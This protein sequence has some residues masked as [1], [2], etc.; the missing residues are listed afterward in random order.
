MFRYKL[1]TL[2][3]LLAVGPPLLAGAWWIGQKEIERRR[4]RSFAELI[5]LIQ[6]TVRP[7][8]WEGVSGPG[9]IT[10]FATSCCV[11]LPPSDECAAYPQFLSLDDESA[12]EDPPI[13]VEAASIDPFAPR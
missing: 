12:D 9:E 7:D 3:I 1:R 2:L 10:S 6:K 11:C 4:Q 13:V 5:E 8:S